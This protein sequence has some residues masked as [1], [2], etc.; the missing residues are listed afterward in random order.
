MLCPPYQ[1]YVMN[2]TGFVEV[3]FTTQAFRVGSDFP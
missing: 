1:K 2:R 3:D